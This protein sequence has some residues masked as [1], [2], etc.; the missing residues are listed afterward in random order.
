[1]N[2]NINNPKPF[3]SAQRQTLNQ[4]GLSGILI[5]NDSGLPIYIRKYSNS[6]FSSEE[7]LVISAFISSISN[8]IKIYD[9]TELKGFSTSHYHIFIQIADE[10]IYCFVLNKNILKLHAN[11]NLPRILDSTMKELIKSFSIYY[12]MTKTKDFIEKNFLTAFESQIDTL[13]LFN[14]SKWKN[15]PY[16]STGTEDDF[17]FKNSDE[18]LSE[19]FNHKF[20]KN[21]IL[22]LFVLGSDNS[23]LVIRDYAVN[24]KYIK[25]ADY[26]QRIVMTLKNFKYGTIKDIGIGDTRV[27]IRTTKSITFCLV[28]SEQSYWKHID[29][30][31]QNYIDKLLQNPPISLTLKPKYTFDSNKNSIKSEMI[32]STN[33]LVDQWLFNNLSLLK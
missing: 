19:T 3:F 33:Y 7:E 27:A 18:F 25:L 16:I 17:Y 1:M 20:L 30:S 29:Q 5:L 24:Q 22:G 11:N 28:I 26:Y 13:L 32:Y 6:K 15:T 2:V 21:G 12:R 8:F 14:L 23:P 31:E 4:V 9:N 10:I